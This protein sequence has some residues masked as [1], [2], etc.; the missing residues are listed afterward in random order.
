MD[1]DSC[2]IPTVLTAKPPSKKEITEFELAP[3]TIISAIK[4]L[5]R[6]QLFYHISNTEWNIHQVIIHLADTEIFFCERMR[7]VI[8]EEKPL[9]QSFDQDIWTNHLYYEKQ[10]YHTAL[11]LLIVQRKSTAGLLRVLPKEMWKRT[12]TQAEKVKT[13]YDIFTTAKRHIPTHLQQIIDI[14]HHSKFPTSR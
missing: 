8:A 6:K 9:L 11:D 13:L 12:G 10:D 5:T 7:K 4:G 14:K 2:A 3:Q 1:T